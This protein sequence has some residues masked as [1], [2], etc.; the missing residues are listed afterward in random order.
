MQLMRLLLCA[1]Y[2]LA[3]AATAAPLKA[4]FIPKGATQIFWKE[5]ARGAEDTARN[6]H[7][8]MVWRGPSQ[9]DGVDAQA[10]IIDFYIQQK[11]SGIILAPNSTAQLDKPIR[12]AINKGIKVVIVDSPLTGQNTLPYVGTNN[13]EAGALAAAQAAKDFPQ[14]KKIL[15]LRYSAQH[16]STTERE[17]GF[18]DSIHKLLPN[19]EVIDTQYAGISMQA[20]ESTANALLSRIPDIDLIFTPNESSTEGTVRALKAKNLA[21]KTHH[22]GFDFNHKINEAIKDGSLNGAVIQD[23]FLM[24]QKA[25]RTLFELLKNKQTPA[26]LETPAIMITTKNINNPEIR[27][28]TDPFLKLYPR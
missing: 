19:A 18:L 28:K 13:K 20:A 8:E 12:E 21:G 27:L 9:E 3:A 23:P 24:G 25:M 4:V 14:T 6:L 5:M 17:T 7:I 22:Y 11:Y 16:G 10:R 1:A 2:L 26:L 15:L